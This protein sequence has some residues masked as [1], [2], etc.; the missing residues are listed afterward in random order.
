MPTDNLVPLLTSWRTLTEMVLDIRSPATFL[1]NFLWASESTEATN[2]FDVEMKFRARIAAPLVRRGAKSILIGGQGTTNT[3]MQA[4]CISLSKCFKP[5]PLMYGRLPGTGIYPTAQ[6]IS[7]AVNIRIAEEMSELADMVTNTQAVLC[8]QA[9]QG[10]ISYAVPDNEVYRCTFQRSSSTNRVLSIFWNASDLSTVNFH[11]EVQTWK[12]VMIDN[13]QLVPTDALCGSEAAHAFRNLA[14]ANRI[15]KDNIFGGA[16][17]IQIGQVD[18]T[19]QYNDQGVMFLGRVDG[20]NFWDV[21]MVVDFGGV[22]T[23]M[24]RPKFVEVISK[25][26][27]SDRKMYFGPIE[28]MKALRGNAFVSK[29]FSK[30]WEQEDPSAVMALLKSNPLPVPRRPD[31]TIS[32]KV[33]SG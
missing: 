28:D 7:S 24:I 27:R 31:A 19:Q 16:G 23:P 21:R 14:L 15:V 33:V 29:R 4:P 5:S 30:S 3:S 32:V 18:F 1:Q 22:A 11:G 20:I 10:V 25:D 13:A 2:T 9:L 26:A 8:A 12:E 6:D 17:V